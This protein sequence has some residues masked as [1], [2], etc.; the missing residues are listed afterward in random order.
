MPPAA[1]PTVFTYVPHMWDYIDRFDRWHGAPF[2][3]SWALSN[4]LKTITGHRNKFQ[5][6]AER[7][8]SLVPELIEERQ[9]FNRQ[10][11]SCGSKVR[12]FTA[13]SETL[14][15]EL[16]SCLDGLRNTIHAIYEPVKGVQK[17]S[18]DKMFKN[19]VE[20]KYGNGFP[21]EIYGWLK[22]AYDDWFP[23]L[24]R[25]RVELT[26]GR[27][28]NCSIKADLSISY[29]HHG[30]GS[31]SD[32]DVFIIDNMIDWINSHAN[33]VNIL[34]NTICKFWFDQLEPREVIE[35]CGVHQGRL[36]IRA[37]EITEP[38][39]RDSGLCLFRHVFEE[40]P[41]WAC[42]MRDSCAAYERVG[43][44]SRAV[45]ARLT[46]SSECEG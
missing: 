15:C 13:I 37:I 11:Y 39:S 28:G 29:V 40:E 16:Y 31:T 14:I 24:R 34:L 1:L 21:P 18:T 41:E 26:H 3:D 9:L 12:E 4:G 7:A 46:S 45:L 23:E 10:R 44:D 22:A 8:T 33:H 5:A 38:V 42:P 36:I 17:K 25:L 32:N 20:K 19:A 30:L 2:S 35:T 27:V 43:G 6:L